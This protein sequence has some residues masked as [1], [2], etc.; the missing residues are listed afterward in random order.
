MG[1]I[2]VY[3]LRTSKKAGPPP[4]IL[5]WR[6]WAALPGLGVDAVKAKLDTG[7]RTSSLHA[8]DMERFQ[9][10]GNAMVR[11]E[12]HPEQRSREGAVEVEAEVVDE[13]WVRNSGGARELRPVIET[14]VR[15][16][17]KSWI[18]E[19]TLTRR[20]EMGF[21]MLL[22]RQALRKRAVVDPGSSYRAGRRRKKKRK[23]KNN[24]IG[25]TR[26]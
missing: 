23:K 11:F 18:I 3:T 4:L 1:G 2:R 20:D 9:R 22:G 17:E 15:L 6:E 21:R 10:D 19:L 12:I 16:A 14:E 24:G 26:R 7:A 13:R 5:G 25:R 8:F